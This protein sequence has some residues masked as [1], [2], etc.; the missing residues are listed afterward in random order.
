MSSTFAVGKCVNELVVAGADTDQCTLAMKRRHPLTL[1][2]AKIIQLNF[3]LKVK[4][5]G[6]INF[7]GSPTTMISSEITTLAYNLHKE[8]CKKIVSLPQRFQK[9][10]GMSTV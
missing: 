2:I 1:G 7:R 4:P 6:V 3:P 8:E 10:T 5:N 9:M